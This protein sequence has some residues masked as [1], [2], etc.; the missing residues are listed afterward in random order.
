MVTKLLTNS[1]TTPLNS[2]RATRLKSVSPD[3]TGGSYV[4]ELVEAISAN[5]F[6][7]VLLCHT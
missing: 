1:H 6:V 5:E 2:E 7:P 4:G 3:S